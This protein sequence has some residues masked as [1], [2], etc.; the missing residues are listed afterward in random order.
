[1]VNSFDL[2]KQSLDLYRQ[3]SEFNPSRALS[4]L[5]T[6]LEQAVAYAQV[7]LHERVE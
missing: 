2:L 3:E 7:F 1:V 5:I 6:M 4:I